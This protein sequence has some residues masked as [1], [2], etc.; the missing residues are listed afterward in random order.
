[1][2]RRDLLKTVLLTLLPRPAI[3]APAVSTLIGNGTAGYSDLQ[4]NNPYG[5]I[6][7]RD[8]ALYFCDV[9]NQRIRRLDLKSRTIRTIAGD[10]QRALQRRWRSCHLWIAEYAARDRLRRRESHVHRRARQPRRA[11]SRRTHRRHFNARR[12]R[13]RWIHPAT[14]ARLRRRSSDSRTA[15]RSGQMAGCSS[16]TSAT[17]ASA[18]SILRRARSS[19]SA[20]LASACPRPMA[21]R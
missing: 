20:A 16:A 10:G 9:D 19:P 14:A 1:M 7:G 6:I 2:H 11:K 17:I 12:H 21:L 4:V 13:R 5:V 3:A 15:S 8:R 18:R